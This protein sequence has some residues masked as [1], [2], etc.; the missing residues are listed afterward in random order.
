M[1]AGDLPFHV[2]LENCLSDDNLSLALQE[3][4]EVV[5][6]AVFKGHYSRLTPTKVPLYMKSYKEVV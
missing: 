3:K 4:S 2:V 1:G 5:Q 6:A